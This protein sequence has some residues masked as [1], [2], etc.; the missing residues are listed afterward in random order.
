M[1]SIDL[2]RRQSWKERQ[3]TS[4]VPRVYAGCSDSTN[5]A[6]PAN[7]KCMRNKPRAR[8]PSNGRNCV[9]PPL[10]SPT[11]A[12]YANYPSLPDACMHQVLEDT[13]AR[14]QST[15]CCADSERA[16]VNVPRGG[17][18]FFYFYFTTSHL[19]FSLY[20][21]ASSSH[22]GFLLS[23]YCALFQSLVVAV[24]YMRRNTPFSL[25]LLHKRNSKGSEK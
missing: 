2:G 19:R 13:R 23:S 22:L 16:R 4:Y 7:A 15:R 3:T 6:P 1:G 8:M 24:Y 12:Q 17:C 20:R 5:Y 25:S 9:S 11:P 10:P 18:F 14:V 21:L